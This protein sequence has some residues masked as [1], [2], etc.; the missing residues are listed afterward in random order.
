[1]RITAPP[2]EIKSRR[3]AS[4][5]TER[6]KDASVQEETE[7][8]DNGYYVVV[9]QYADWSRALDVAGRQNHGIASVVSA[10]GGGDKRHRV[11]VGPLKR[12]RA[13][14]V[15][16]ALLGDGYDSAWLV[17]RCRSI[18]AETPAETCLDLAN[19]WR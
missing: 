3:L 12:A 14:A 6:G 11:L 2:P 15:R 17:R 19:T 5:E 10:R 8:R 18:P 1:M 7:A 13:H 16:F 4:A 9:G